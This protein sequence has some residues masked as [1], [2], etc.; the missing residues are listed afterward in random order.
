MDLVLLHIIIVPLLL[1]HCIWLSLLPLLLSILCA[2]LILSI[3]LSVYIIH[4]I[5]S[6]GLLC[7]PWSLWYYFYDGVEHG[8]VLGVYWSDACLLYI[9]SIGLVMDARLLCGLA[10]LVISTSLACWRANSTPISIFKAR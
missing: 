6:L 5:C 9:G 8:S 10:G 1:I 4:V 3:S 2:I 7:W